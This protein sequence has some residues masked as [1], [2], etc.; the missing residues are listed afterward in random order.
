MRMVGLG[1]L[2]V[3]SWVE[4]VM[5]RGLATVAEHAT[6]EIRR[7]LSVTFE[8][9]DHALLFVASLEDLV[10]VSGSRVLSCTFDTHSRAYGSCRLPCL[11]VI[12]ASFSNAAIVD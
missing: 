8:F 6:L 2:T 10:T 1:S 5:L 4:S 7:V 3:T 9:F 12:Y 11:H